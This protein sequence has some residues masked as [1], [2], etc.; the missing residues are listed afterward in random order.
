MSTRPHLSAGDQRDQLRVLR[1]GGLAGSLRR[2]SWSRSV[3][4]AL[5]QLAPEGLVVEPLPLALPHYD[6]DLDHDGPPA[7]VR[8]LRDTVTGLDGLIVVTPEYNYGVPGVLKNTLDWLSR[9]AYRSPL[10][11]LPVTIVG[12]APG[13]IGGARSLGQ[14]KQVLAGTA[15]AIHPWPETVVNHVA[16]RFTDGQLV[17]EE[18]SSRLIRQLAAF[19][20][21]VD[22]VG[23]Y[24][25]ARA[26]S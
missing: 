9:P 1:T 10:R 17:D 16:D 14:L 20:H 23:A 8:A 19:G 15:S 12:V 13:P 11:D 6:A 7:E 26:T 4:D 5:A 18:T 3:L 24:R 21:W 22:A 25:T 2:D